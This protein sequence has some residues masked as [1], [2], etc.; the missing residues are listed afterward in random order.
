MIVQLKNAHHNSLPSRRSVSSCADCGGNWNEKNKKGATEYPVSFSASIACSVALMVPAFHHAP[1]HSSSSAITA[2]SGIITSV[3]RTSAR[4]YRRSSY[5]HH[6]SQ[7]VASTSATMM[8]HCAISFTTTFPP[9]TAPSLI[10]KHQRRRLCSFAPP[11]GRALQSRSV[12]CAARAFRR[13]QA[14]AAVPVSLAS[15]H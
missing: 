2:H 3:N 1:I 6:H 12:R 15:G 8:A 14:R 10:H 5:A 13:T 4:I 11:A 9:P 7:A